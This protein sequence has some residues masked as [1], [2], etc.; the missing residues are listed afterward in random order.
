[1]S[2]QTTGEGRDYRKGQRLGK[3]R[4][5]L[6]PQ[7]PP[8]TQPTSHSY[9]IATSVELIEGSQHAILLRAGLLGLGKVVFVATILALIWKHHPCEKTERGVVLFPHCFNNLTLNHHS[10]QKRII[11]SERRLI[12]LFPFTYLHIS[13][14]LKHSPHT[15]QPGAY[16]YRYLRSSELQ[17]HSRPRCR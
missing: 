14:G 17:S 11:D 5:N 15:Q 12:H 7:P 10:I 2:D 8:G 9:M 3:V 1:M 13:K 4:P 6:S 16:D